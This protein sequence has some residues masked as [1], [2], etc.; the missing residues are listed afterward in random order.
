MAFNQGASVREWAQ[1]DPS[2]SRHWESSRTA[3]GLH[4]G[5]KIF[6]LRDE[7]K[8]VG[9]FRGH[10]MLVLA[11]AQDA[12]IDK[13]LGPFRLDQLNLV[14]LVLDFPVSG[15]ALPSLPNPVSP[16]FE[17]APHD[18]MSVANPTTILESYGLRDS[19]LSSFRGKSM[20]ILPNL[21]G[22]KHYEI[23]KAAIQDSGVLPLPADGSPA[24]VALLLNGYWPQ[25]LLS[26]TLQKCEQSNTTKFYCLG[27][28]LQLPISYWPFREVWCNGA[29]VVF[30]QH[31][32]LQEPDKVRGLMKKVRSVDNWAAYIT[33]LSLLYINEVMNVRRSCPDK[34]ETFALLSE[35]LFT[36]EDLSP[37]AGERTP[38]SG[39]LAVS[40]A[41]PSLE[42]PKLCSDWLDW[43]RQVS[44]CKN[45]GAMI[46]LCEQWVKDTGG[47][48]LRSGG[49]SP[50]KA[51]GSLDPFFVDEQSILDLADMRSRPEFVPY[52]RF[53]HVGKIAPGLDQKHQNRV[54]FLKLDD[55]DWVFANSL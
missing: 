7:L 53:I 19:V 12:H 23:V 22:S 48:A 50:T 27:P 26:G 41:L 20:A 39:G 40:Q 14:L 49:M 37:L 21:P 3:A 5:D 28:D 42:R 8:P 43:Q 13:V 11:R 46:E 10:G 30:S 31:T 18:P 24:E 16:D 55:L 35:S 45:Y 51:G 4:R 29:L 15:R 33:P 17:V 36:N 25:L 54:E 38:E 34:N 9:A 44:Q 1:V 32:I 2:T 6:V 47:R 52:R